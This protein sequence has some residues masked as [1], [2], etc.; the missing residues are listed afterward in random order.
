MN[1]RRILHTIIACQEVVS[2]SQTNSDL[3]Q[4]TCDVLVKIGGLQMA[5]IGIIK[6]E[7][8]E[9]QAQAGKVDGY[10]KSINLT[11]DKNDEMGCP[12]AMAVRTG[13]SYLVE[14]ILR[15]PTEKSWKP[16]ALRRGYASVLSIPLVKKQQS[17][18]SIC[19]YAGEAGFLA[20]SNAEYFLTIADN[21][22]NSIDA[23][24]M[25]NE[26]YRA[27]YE[28]NKTLEK[29]RWTLGAV[30]QALE[31]AVEVRDPYTLGHQRRVAD[32]ART[33][34]TKMN[35][36]KDRIDGIRIGGI[37]HDI[38]KIYVPAEIL[39]KP[40]RL[41]EVEFNLVKTHPQVGYDI[42][43]KIE[44]PWPIGQIILQHHE[45]I[46][47]SGY[48]N[49][50]KDKDLLLEAKILGVADVIEAMASHRPYRAA[51]GVDVA[52]EEIKNKR[53][54]LYDPEVVDISIGL[55]KDHGY[56]FKD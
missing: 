44:F 15:H 48:P 37:L 12:A 40:R 49:G 47:G 43:K 2:K 31:N 55:F 38:G 30:I 8:I 4:K 50:L 46:D 54:I 29:L 9:P 17:F 23:L 26:R 18:G 21:L 41:T 45:R 22:V 25:R 28:L 51:L 1:D 34:A 19:L 56:T 16:E 27:Q 32:L 7:I 20:K 33:I 3:L 10:L 5:W 13:E 53:G 36:S 14:D 39:T 42:L 52:L 6:G 35:L 11:C 24:N